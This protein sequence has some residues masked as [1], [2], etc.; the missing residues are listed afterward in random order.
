M[1]SDVLVERNNVVERRPP[2]E[3]DEVPAHGK[4][5]EGDVDY[6][7]QMGSGPRLHPIQVYRSR[8][9]PE[10]STPKGSVT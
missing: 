9:T 3:R 1:K 8:E 2:E 6:E 7:D 10:A 4:E 5:D